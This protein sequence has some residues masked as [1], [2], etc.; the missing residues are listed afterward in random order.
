MAKVEV[1]PRGTLTINDWKKQGKA[2]VVWFAPVLLMYIT[3]VLGVIQAEGH[4]IHYR[5]F[6]PSTMTVGAGVGWFLSQIQGIILRW[7]N[8]TK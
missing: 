2:A 4:N 6:V 8:E 3:A 7:Q 1:S 5:D